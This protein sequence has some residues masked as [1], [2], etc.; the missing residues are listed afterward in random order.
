MGGAGGKQVPPLRAPVGMKR[1]GGGGPLGVGELP[2]PEGCG[3]AGEM[4]G[5]LPFDFAQG[6]L[7]ARNDTKKKGND[8]AKKAE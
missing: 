4:R 8:K 3:G 1:L 5:F 7:F 2:E 6:R